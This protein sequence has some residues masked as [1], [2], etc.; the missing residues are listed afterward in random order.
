MKIKITKEKAVDDIKNIFHVSSV[1]DKKEEDI[2]SFYSQEDGRTSF[3]IDKRKYNRMEVIS[4]L[5]EYFSDKYISEGQCR[6][7]SITLLYTVFHI[8]DRE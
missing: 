1:N 3:F 7:E 2:T 8:E 6:I 5:S 4:S